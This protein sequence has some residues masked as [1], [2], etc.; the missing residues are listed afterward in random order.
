MAGTAPGTDLGAGAARSQG[1][2]HVAWQGRH[3]QRIDTLI[4]GDIVR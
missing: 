1:R 2:V 3:F 4:D